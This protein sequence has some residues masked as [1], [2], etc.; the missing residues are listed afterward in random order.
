M[1]QTSSFGATIIEM[2]TTIQSTK[3]QHLQSQKQHAFEYIYKQ[4]EKNNKCICVCVLEFYTHWCVCMSMSM[5]QSNCTWNSY[6]KN[7]C[8]EN[9]CI[10]KLEKDEMTCTDAAQK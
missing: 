1:K 6:E 2:K 4:H 9:V 3:I 10:Y 8:V 5:S 7:K